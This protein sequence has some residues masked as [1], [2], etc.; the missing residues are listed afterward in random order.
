[1]NQIIS[2]FGQHFLSLDWDE[3]NQRMYGFDTFKELD[4][5]ID[6]VTALPDNSQVLFHRKSTQKLYML[7]RK[8]K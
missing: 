3:E 6:F 5:P 1:M 4:E 2:I 7:N 8:K